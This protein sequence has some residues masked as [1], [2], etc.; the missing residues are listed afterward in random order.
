MVDADDKGT[1]KTQSFVWHAGHS[2]WTNSFTATAG[3]C[4]EGTVETYAFGTTDDMTAED[5]SVVTLTMTGVA[6]VDSN[7]NAVTAP[8][9]ASPAFATITVEDLVPLTVSISDAAAS[10]SA[11]E[12]AFSVSL[13]R[14]HIQDVMVTWTA[15]DGTATEGTHYTGTSGT[16]TIKDGETHGTLSLPVVDDTAN[17]AARTFTVTFSNATGGAA[18]DTDHTAATGTILD[19]EGSGEQDIEMW[20][21]DSVQIESD[22]DGMMQFT[23]RLSE[24]HPWREITVDYTTSPGTATAGE[25][26]THTSGTLTFPAREGCCDPIEVPIIDD[27]EDEDKTETFTVTLSDPQGA[28]LTGASAT[29]TIY[30]DDIDDTGI[31]LHIDVWPEYLKDD[32]T[33]KFH[34]D[35][36]FMVQFIFQHPARPFE[37]IAVTGFDENDVTVTATHANTRT[38]FIPPTGTGITGQFYNLEVTLGDTSNFNV[39]IEV[40]AGAAQGTGD[41]SA[42]GNQEASLRVRN[43]QEVPQSLSARAGIDVVI[44]APGP[45]KQGRVQRDADGGFD[46]DISF[47]DP[48]QPVVGIPVTDF[49]PAD[50]EVT[51]TVPTG[52]AE[53]KDDASNINA[54]GSETFAL[55]EAGSP[56]REAPDPLTAAFRNLPEEHDGASAFDFRVEFSEDIGNSYVTLRDEAFTVTGGGVTGAHRV[57]GRN[58]L[59]EITVK[60]DAREEIT[61][62]LPGGRAC[63]TTGAL[64]TAGDDPGR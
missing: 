44:T 25:D 57:D 58:D 60:P 62:T 12:I 5:D 51:V 18:L 29:G 63:G 53:A 28:T 45:K 52:V 4:S 31:E 2:C 64:C 10:E 14:A 37:G 24:T 7:D 15:S 33:I 54:E 41:Y 20:I 21:E 35:N 11:G 22:S 6:A 56:V 40:A 9:L 17:N 27:S 13:S 50:V 59:W 23:V 49:T 30:D 46:V 42:T 26:Y 47:V 19:D 36:K 48:T 8:S 61:I 16:L 55:A 39:F 43:G 38:R 32:G 34:G 1:G 3:D